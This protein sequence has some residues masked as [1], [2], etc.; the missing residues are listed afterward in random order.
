MAKTLLE[1]SKTPDLQKAIEIIGAECFGALS[2][3]NIMTSNSSPVWDII[4]SASWAEIVAEGQ[5]RKLDFHTMECAVTKSPLL[6]SATIQYAL[7]HI[8]EKERTFIFY[9]YVKGGDG[10]WPDP[11]T[12]V[13]APS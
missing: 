8:T 5:A 2:A 11:L 4:H 10:S 3:C 13:F 12:E 6:W 1:L 9:K 7:G